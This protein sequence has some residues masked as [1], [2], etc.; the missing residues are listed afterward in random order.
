[1]SFIFVGILYFCV[2]A[3]CGMVTSTQG[4]KIEAE[5]LKEVR[6]LKAGFQEKG[7]TLTNARCAKIE[8]ECG[9]SVQARQE[10]PHQTF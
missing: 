3:N 1:M 5:C 10:R 7:A 8:V 2:N 9:R 6:L 4:F